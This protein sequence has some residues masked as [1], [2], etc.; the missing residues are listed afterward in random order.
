MN[1]M[2]FKT[3][4]EWDST[5]LHNNGSEVHA[6]QLFV[7]LLAG[8][9]EGGTPVRGGIARGGELTA[10]VRLQSNPEKEAG[11][12]PGRLEMIFP[13]HQVA[14]E[15]RHPSFAF[16]ATRVWH[17]GKEVTN[18]VVELYVDINAVDNVV[19]AYITIYRPHWFGPDE[20]ATYNI[21]GG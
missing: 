14:V 2:V 5:F 15:N 19:R 8:R 21:L 10:I 16:E 3:G 13:R 17:N 11:I 20:V 9:D 1:E 12:L 7:Q 4:G 18:S 6:A